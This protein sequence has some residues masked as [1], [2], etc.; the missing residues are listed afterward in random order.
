MKKTLVAVSLATM[1]VFAGLAGATPITPTW[2]AGNPSATGLGYD[3][4]YK[5]DPPTSGTYDAGPGSVTVTFSADGRYIDWTSTF[6]ID[7][8]IVKGGEDANVFVYNPPA[9]SFGDTGL[10]APLNGGGKRPAISHVEFAWNE[11]LVPEPTTL[12]LLGLGLVGL[13]GL[14]RNSKG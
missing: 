9:P 8:V 14:R 10:Y 3:F 6:G 4:G 2:V 13:A 12:L 1:M 11:V 7:A 5:I